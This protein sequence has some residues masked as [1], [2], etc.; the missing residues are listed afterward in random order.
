MR[1]DVLTC[2]HGDR[3]GGCDYLVVPYRD[4][5]DA[6]AAALAAALAP[7]PSLGGVPLLATR[8]ADPARGYRTR[9]KWMAGPQA[10]LG[11][12]TRG[13]HQVVDTPACAVASPTLAAVGAA[14]RGLLRDPLHD[15]VAASLRAVDLREVQP[16]SAVVAGPSEAL[17]TLVL[18]REE[19]PSRRALESFAAALRTARPEVIGV[20]ANWAAKRSIQ[21]LGPETELV[22][23]VG[24]ALDQQGDVAVTASAGG[25]VQAHRGQAA[26]MA[27]TLVEGIAGAGAPGRRASARP[28]VLELFAGASPFGLAL[29]RAGCDVTSVESFAPAVE[30]ARAAA[31]AQGLSLRAIVADAEGAAEDLARWRERFD[32][33]VVDPPRRGLSPRLRAAIAALGPRRVAYVSCDPQTLARDLADLRWRGLVT[34]TIEPWDFVPQTTQVEALAWLSPGGLPALERLASREGSVVVDAPPHLDARAVA[35]RSRDD[36]LVPASPLPLG[37]SGALLLAARGAVRPGDVEA[38]DV[39]VAVRGV[40]HAA[41]RGLPGE[42]R[43]RTRGEGRSLLAVDGGSAAEVARLPDLLGRAGHPVLGDPRDAATTRHLLEK[44]GVDRPL[45]HVA[46]LVVRG[47][48]RVTAPLAP[49]M[50]AALARLG[51]R[52]VASRG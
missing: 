20:L 52:A 8:A 29:A 18:V 6:K 36:G 11:L 50:L 2:E 31:E 13:S 32:A 17:V 21:I 25:F 22:A 35:A 39:V 14:L 34:S 30:G 1:L 49:D 47:I 24:S 33:I 42:V 27:R 28:R 48:G 51:L 40:P 37:A 3:C 16:P 4:Q 43:V 19:R 38:M 26:A 9:I 46:S 23:G 12:Y 15:R 44:H 5:L 45:L 10:A 41:L 7:Y